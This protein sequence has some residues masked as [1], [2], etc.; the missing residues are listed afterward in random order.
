ML[1]LCVNFNQAKE[2]YLQG[3]VGN[4]EGADKPNK[5]KY[6]PRVWCRAAEQSFVTRLTEAYR[7]LNSLQVIPLQARM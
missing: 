4:P 7:D 6:D 1:C 2:G 5:K 3:Q